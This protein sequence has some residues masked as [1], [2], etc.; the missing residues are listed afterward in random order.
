MGF[1][2][3][4]TNFTLD[5]RIAMTEHKPN[6]GLGNQVTV[7]FNL[8][9]RFHCAISEKDEQYTENFFK[10]IGISE[11][12]KLSFKGFTDLMSKLPRDSKND[13]WLQ[14]FGLNSHRF[15]RNPITGLFDDQMMIN[16]LR[17]S[18]DDPISNF[19][20]RNVPRALKAV[21]IMGMIQA[22]KW[23][24]GTLNDFR[25]FFGL[26]RH[27][28]FEQISKN[29]EVQNALRDLYDHPDKVELYPGVFCESNQNKDLENMDLDPGPSDL[30]S[31][32][33]SAIFSDAITLVRSDRFY[34]DWNTNSLTSWGMK[35]VTPDNDNL[36]SSVFHRLLQRAFPEWFPYD[37]IRF[38]HPFYT[39]QA[40]AKFAKLQGYESTFG[41]IEEKTP[42]DAHGKHYDVDAFEPQKPH[43]PV[44]LTKYGDIRSVLATGADEIL[45]PAFTNGENLPTKVEE[46]LPKIKANSDN[47]GR[48][49]IAEHAEITKTYFAEQMRAIVKR[50]VIVM[51]ENTFQVDVTR[52]VAIPV[53]TR[54]IAD[55]LGF[56]D[57]IRN[58]GNPQAKYPENEIYQHITNCQVFL[59][60]NTDETKLLRRRAAFRKSME[61]LLRLAEEGNIR[62]ASRWQVTRT[63]RGFF[64]GNPVASQDTASESMR[65]LGCSVAARVSKNEHDSGKAAAILL[66]TALDI[67]FISVLAF[68]AVI[69]HLL[70]GAY[71]VAKIGRPGTSDWLQIQALAMKDE[72]K[73]DEEIQHKVLEALR[74]SVKLPFIRK[75]VKD[76]V[77]IKVDGEDCTLKKDQTIVCDVYEA[78]QALTMEEVRDTNKYCHLNYVSS[79]SSALVHFNPKDIA[80]HGLTAMIKVMA[81]MKNLR[82][83]HTAQGHVKKIQIDQTCEGY[84]N[85]MAPGR[86]QMIAS[87]AKHAKMKLQRYKDE[88]HI[89]MSNQERKAEEKLLRQQIEDARKIFN[90]DI[91][92]PKADTYLT[93]KWD[94]MIPFP[95]TWKVRFDGYG[96]SRYDDESDDDG[97]PLNMLRTDPLPDDKPP[98]YPPRGVS[99][100]GGTFGDVPKEMPADL[101][102][103]KANGCG[104][105]GPCLHSGPA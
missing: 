89:D 62:E 44:Y 41:K 60:Y 47:R 13:P 87:D 33:W 75:V 69:D 67:A 74:Q 27:K 49:D 59:S 6:R 51:N 63:V 100:Y 64:Q 65:A 8:L 77:T 99:H 81:Q 105:P 71:D 82:R 30:D 83:G 90:E 43:K 94:E 48:S 26:G 3:Y 38:F 61:F 73:S 104:V 25:E 57:Q 55:F 70:Q 39:S 22:R 4:D 50:E 54:C 66:L 7:E 76:D 101:E 46:A 9:Y 32:L 19:G 35:E 37:S 68:T 84:A 23:E 103:P 58:I 85:F 79:L 42:K 24:I 5:P 92:R 20:P 78:M 28:T 34:T 88:D 52:D 72:S 10:E 53:V 40:N 97:R 86:M 1:H 18:M 80:L 21:E 93:A 17:E 98:F 56:G 96:E 11:P 29:T 12:R 45:H 91:L 2:Q 36:K 95:T 16:Q 102:P 15:K 14:E 31:A